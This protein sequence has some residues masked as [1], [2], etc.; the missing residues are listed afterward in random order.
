MICRRALRPSQVAGPDGLDRGQARDGG[1]RPGPGRARSGVRWRA[2]ASGRWRSRSIWPWR[3]TTVL[4]G[5]HRH[6]SEVGAAGTGDYGRHPMVVH[7]PWP[8]VVVLDV[9][10]WAVWSAVAGWWT[11]RWTAARGPAAAVD[12]PLLRLRPFE[13]GRPPVPAPAPGQ[14]LEALAAGGRS[15]LRRTVQLP[16]SRPVAEGGLPRFLAECRRAERT[17]WLI[18]AATPVLRCGTRP[19]CSGPWSSFALVANVPCLVVL[20]YNR[21]RLLRRTVRPSGAAKRR[22]ASSSVVSRTPGSAA[23]QPR[24]T[25][26]DR[27]HAA[28]ASPALRAAW[29][30]GRSSWRSQAAARPGPARQRPLVRRGP[31]DDDGRERMTVVLAWARRRPGP[32]RRRAPRPRPALGAGPAMSRAT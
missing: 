26:A 20:R 8:W 13:A 15:G 32:D 2:P 19:A 23:T 9:V 21:A 3:M 11:G 10:A 27:A 6:G 29:P 24:A 5:A 28:T 16:P 12:G 31:V 14:D 18:L 1:A 30:G 4:V 7:L 25:A 17:H 22:S